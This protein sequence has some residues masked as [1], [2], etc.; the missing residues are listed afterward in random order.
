MK[1]TLQAIILIIC[2][3]DINCS[4]RDDWGQFKFR[5]N[6]TYITEKEDDRRFRIF[7]ANVREIRNHNRKFRRNLFTFEKGVNIFADLTKEEFNERYSLEETILTT[8]YARDTK[9]NLPRGLSELDNH[10]Y[11]DWR[12]KGAVTPAKDQGHCASCWIF[13]AVGVLEAYYFRKT[14]ALVSLSMQN[15]VDC[16]W[17]SNCSGG[18]PEFAFEFAKEYGLNSESHYP[19]QGK[20]LKCNPVKTKIFNLT[21]DELKYVR[22]SGSNMKDALIEY[23]PLSV[24]IYVTS[25]WRFYKS[26]VYYDKECSEYVNHCLLVVGY[27]TENGYDYWIMKNSWGPLWGEN[28]FIKFSRNEYLNYCGILER[29]AYVI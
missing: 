12:E 29:A 20:E 15:I 23:G 7:L 14:G 5:Y 6:K 1:S 2:W 27:G 11:F 3:N 19:Y 26:G 8:I 18:D 24:C 16:L 28:G 21:F 13:S 9:K 4:L 22:N 17:D 25:K 10:D